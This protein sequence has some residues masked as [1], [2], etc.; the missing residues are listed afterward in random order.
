MAAFDYDGWTV[1]IGQ[2]LSASQIPPLFSVCHLLKCPNGFFTHV[3]HALFRLLP[4][5]LSLGRVP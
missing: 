1:A 2:F 3:F 5:G 4:C